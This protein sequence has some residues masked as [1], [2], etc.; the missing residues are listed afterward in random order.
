MR[1]STASGWSCWEWSFWFSVVARK[2]TPAPLP[3][4]ECLILMSPILSLYCA[5]VQHS[6][7]CSTSG[8]AIQHPSFPLHWCQ[9]LFQLIQVWLEITS[10]QLT[11]HLAL[12]LPLPERPWIRKTQTET[13]ISST[14][15]SIPTTTTAMDSLSKT[16][17]V[18]LFFL[19]FKFR[20]YLLIALSSFFLETIYASTSFDRQDSLL[21][22]L[23]REDWSSSSDSFICEKI[24]LVIT[25]TSNNLRDPSNTSSTDLPHCPLESVLWVTDNWSKSSMHSYRSLSPL[26]LW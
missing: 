23:R 7:L 16:V 1:R 21:F 12:I 10:K 4:W 17:E 2:Q 8:Q 24:S 18:Q 9:L 19:L 3:F 22:L 11:S 26:N 5:L 25:H 14:S 20:R 13:L 6:C 15:L